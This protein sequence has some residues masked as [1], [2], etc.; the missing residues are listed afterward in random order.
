VRKNSKT[1]GEGVWNEL[2]LM[3]TDLRGIDLAFVIELVFV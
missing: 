1:L 2:N 3:L